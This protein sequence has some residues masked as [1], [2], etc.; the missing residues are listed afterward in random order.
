MIESDAYFYLYFLWNFCPIP[1][2]RPF[3]NHTVRYGTV[4]SYRT[5]RVWYLIGFRSSVSTTS[6]S[7]PARSI[8]HYFYIF[9]A[10]L[11]MYNSSLA[12]I[13]FVHQSVRFTKETSS[14]IDSFSW[15]WGTRP[16]LLATWDLLWRKRWSWHRPLIFFLIHT[17]S[18][19]I[20]KTPW[21]PSA[22]IFIW[23]L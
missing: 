3:C 8:S 23:S 20:S 12:V 2:S 16:R 6:D 9:E 19:T 10:W 5:V 18:K 1:E 15:P 7:F 17:L 21:A 13:H 11:S 22:S 4:V 14:L